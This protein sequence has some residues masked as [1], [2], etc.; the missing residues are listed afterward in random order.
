MP[1]A[2]NTLQSVL[3]CLN[4]HLDAE[5]R[6]D[7]AGIMA[8]YSESPRVTI[9][10]QVFA[11]TSAVG[12]FHDRFGFGG[13][14]AFSQVTVRKRARHL[15]GLVVT[16]EQSL[17]GVHTGRWLGYEATG[18]SFDLPVCTVYTFTPEARLSSEDVYFDSVQIL[19][20][21]GLVS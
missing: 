15:S 16:L 7:L 21:L 5:N 3:T 9:N 1:M 17:S 8:T 10:G 19:R 14:G 2:T 4:A 11:G 12:A 13:A 6:H 20:Q 18:R